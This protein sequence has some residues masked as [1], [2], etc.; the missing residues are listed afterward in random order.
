MDTTKFTM[1]IVGLVVIILMVTGAVIPAV[2]NGQSEIRTETQNTGYSYLATST[3][4]LNLTASFDSDTST[5]TING[6]AI[7][8]T[9]T[10]PIF[11]CGDD[12]AVCTTTGIRFEG[13]DGTVVPTA[14]AIEVVDGA[15]TVTTST[16]PVTGDLSGT[17]ITYLTENGKLSYFAPSAS[18]N[19]NEDSKI[20]MFRIGVSISG[21]ARTHIDAVGTVKNLTSIIK[22]STNDGFVEW[23]DVVVTADYTE[24]DGYYTVSKLNYTGTYNG[25][26]YTGSVATMS[27]APTTYKYI[28]DSDSSM[29]SLFSIIPLLLII[30]AVLYAVRLMGASRN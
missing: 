5:L 8:L 16:D 17:S 15:Y 13:A 19:C 26:T 10:V 18:F 6:Y 14:S 12:V 21:V 25:Q 1:G 29:I 30:V 27:F 7:V 23:T 4:N 9:A 22:T 20:Q 24:Q 2:E 28:S 3:D 11:V